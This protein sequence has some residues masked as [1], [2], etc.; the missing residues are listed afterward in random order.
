M[1]SHVI[2]DAVK[3]FGTNLWNHFVEPIG[4]VVRVFEN[5]RETCERKGDEYFSKFMQS[6]TVVASAT[7]TDVDASEIT[8]D[9]LPYADTGK[10]Q[11][12]LPDAE[13][14]KTVDKVT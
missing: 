9:P 13:K 7:V 10:T 4:G 6:D 2:G 14:T 11:L 8:T 12:L 3:A 1:E 5:V